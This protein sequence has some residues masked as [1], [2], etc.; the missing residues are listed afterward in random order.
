MGAPAAVCYDE[1]SVT[2]RNLSSPPIPAGDP[3]AR[4]R[5]VGGARHEA[6]ERVR[7][8]ADDRVIEGW[9]LNASRGGLRLIV[10]D[11]VTVGALFEL[12]VGDVV[13]PIV[14]QCR[15][16]WVQD[17]A[18][19]TICGLKFLDCD[20]PVPSPAGDSAEPPEEP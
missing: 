12:S 5:G 3:Q 13:P 19:G 8:C 17:E 10:E 20:G 18:D 6:S 15:V 2:R 1:N 16:V 11:R 4:R 14:R 7:L 9:T